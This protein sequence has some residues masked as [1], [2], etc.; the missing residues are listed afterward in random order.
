MIRRRIRGIV[1]WLVNHFLC[2]NRLWVV[3]RRLLSATG[4]SVGRN[5]KIVGP[6]TMGVCADLTIGDNCWI[7]KNFCIYGNAAV[8][9]GSNC[10]L[11]PNVSFATGSHETGGHDRRAGAG[12]CEPITVGNGCWLGI[13]STILCGVTVGDGVVVGAG[14]L[15]NK[16]VP[17]DV[18]I[19]GVPAKIV[20]TFD[21]GG[22]L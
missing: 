5:T 11:A 14:A 19:A 9:I 10:D 12:Y 4:I 20:K 1:L 6:I 13:N 16:P 8:S 17:A 18:L 15:V 22:N 2:G 21:E 7:G 3:K